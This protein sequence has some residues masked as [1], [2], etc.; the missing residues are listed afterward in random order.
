MTVGATE[1]VEQFKTEATKAGAI[2]YVAKDA[3]EARDYVL[4]L[5]Q[6]RNVKHIVKSKSMLTEEIGLN[7]HLENA[8]IEIKETDI[9]AWIAQLAGERP[10]D[11]VKPARHKTIEQIAALIS[12]ATGETLKPDPLT[13]VNAA[14][15]ALRQSYI[16]ADMG[17]SEAS[18]AI[19]E[20]GTS[21]ITGDEGNCRLVALLP[22]IHL[23]LIDYEKLVPTIKDATIRLKSI[24]RN[25]NGSRMPSY[26]TYITGRNSTG[27]IP[28]ARDIR[29]QGPEDEYILLIESLKGK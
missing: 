24:G 8:S 18:I 14:R 10:P 15:R 3:K 23:T 1:L 16:D 28:R 29:A 25:K 9:G 13:L 7:E 12:K 11:M 19:A 22:L 4:K 20:T 27:D 17:I 2:V 21:V 26:I 6:E 5:A